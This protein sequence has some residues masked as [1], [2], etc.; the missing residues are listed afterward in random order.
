MELT[1]DFGVTHFLALLVISV[2]FMC[3]VFAHLI[4]VTAS[5]GE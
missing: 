3:S 5:F 4:L 1:I 2:G